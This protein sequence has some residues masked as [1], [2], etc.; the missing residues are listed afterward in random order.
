MKISQLIKELI[1]LQ[2]K[3]GDVEVLTFDLDRELCNVEEVDFSN[4][5]HASVFIG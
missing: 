4:Y 1:E 2:E 5:P 3:H